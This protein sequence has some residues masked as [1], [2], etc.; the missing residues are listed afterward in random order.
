V[1]SRSVPPSADRAARSALPTTPAEKKVTG[2]RADRG[3]FEPAYVTRKRLTAR[4]LLSAGGVGLALGLA[5]FYVAKVWIERSDVM[6]TEPTRR[7]TP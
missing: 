4:E 1:P 2:G 6:P 3:K 7:S 5:A